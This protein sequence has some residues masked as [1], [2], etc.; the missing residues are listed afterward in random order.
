MGRVVP[1]LPKVHKAKKWQRHNFNSDISDSRDVILNLN[2]RTHGIGKV[3]SFGINTVERIL[4]QAFGLSDSLYFLPVSSLSLS[5]SFPT[6][7]P[8]F[9]YPFSMAL[10]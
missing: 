3:L 1:N 10:L 6:P 2:L 7:P 9:I 8:F 4:I 5:L